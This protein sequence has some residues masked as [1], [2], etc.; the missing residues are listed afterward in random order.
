MTFSKGCQHFCPFAS[1]LQ[2]EELASSLGVRDK[3][4]F[5]TRSPTTSA[6]T[7]SPGRWPLYTPRGSTSASSP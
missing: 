1:S 2:L 7:S 4:E 6:R 3:V 5:K